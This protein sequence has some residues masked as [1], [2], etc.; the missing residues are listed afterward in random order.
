MSSNTVLVE[1]EDDWVPFDEPP[2]T[3]NDDQDFEA[4]NNGEEQQSPTI[5]SSPVNLEEFPLPRMFVPGKIVHIYT[6]R[7]G[8]KVS[9][10]EEVVSTGTLVK[11]QLTRQPII[12]G[13]IRATEIQVSKENQHGWEL[14]H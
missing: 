11:V 14:S 1:S 3:N 6:H 13:G 7:G 5:D 8:Y 4:S 12:T 2:M 10:Q 9:T